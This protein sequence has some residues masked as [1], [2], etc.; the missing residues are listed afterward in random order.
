[1]LTK[2]R[3]FCSISDG[4]N[5]LEE[6]QIKSQVANNQRCFVLELC[7]RRKEARSQCSLQSDRKAKFVSTS[8]WSILE[9]SFPELTKQPARNV[10]EEVYWYKAQLMFRLA[11]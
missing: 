9:L 6:Q 7:R 11:T 2:E 1:M 4:E 10:E 8:E 3:E 5:L